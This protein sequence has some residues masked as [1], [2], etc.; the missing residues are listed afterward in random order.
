MLQWLIQ[1]KQQRRDVRIISINNEG[2]ELNNYR[3]K[4]FQLHRCFDV[5]VSSGEIGMRKPDPGI[6]QLALGIVRVEPQ[7]CL[8]FD[9]RPILAEAAQRTGIQ[10]HHHQNFETTKALVENI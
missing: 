7:Q 5:F 10:A 6:F 8:Y 2:K 9:D 3:I 4:K 1:W